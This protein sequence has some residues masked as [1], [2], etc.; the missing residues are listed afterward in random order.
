MTKMSIETKQNLKKANEQHIS[1]T[2]KL[3]E[4]HMQE[5]KKDK[6]EF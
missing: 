5:M 2:K 6:E 4:Q 3:D 1:R